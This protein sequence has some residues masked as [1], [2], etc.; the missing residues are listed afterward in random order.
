LSALVNF[1]IWQRQFFD[2]EVL[3]GSDPSR[4]EIGKAASS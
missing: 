2:G 4:M 1:E 3:H